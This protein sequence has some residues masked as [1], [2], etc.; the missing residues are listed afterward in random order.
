MLQAW[1]LSENASLA[2][3]F[4]INEHPHLS[5]VGSSHWVFTGWLKKTNS[6]SVVLATANQSNWCGV[7]LIDFLIVFVIVTVFVFVI[8]NAVLA[9][10]NL[11]S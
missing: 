8:E 2:N 5:L 6:V 1:Q 4:E 9:M 7:V 3:F 11:W 10:A